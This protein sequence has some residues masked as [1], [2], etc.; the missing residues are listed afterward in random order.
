MRDEEANEV[1][2][3][4]NGEMGEWYVSHAPSLS[5]DSLGHD[6]YQNKGVS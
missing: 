4:L 3:Q 2:A 6:L 1:Q 5:P